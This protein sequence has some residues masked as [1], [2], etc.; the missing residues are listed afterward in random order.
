[1][2]HEV[3]SYVHKVKIS[4]QKEYCHLS[5]GVQQYL[6]DAFDDFERLCERIVLELARLP[7]KDQP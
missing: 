7:L 3:L 6:K 2:A 5:F 1:M 4:L